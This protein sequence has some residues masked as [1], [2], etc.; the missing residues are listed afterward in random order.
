M[1]LY[2]ASMNNKNVLKCVNYYYKTSVIVIN[3][4]GSRISV[5]GVHMYKDVV[6]RFA[7]FISFLSHIP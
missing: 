2:L 6:V 1:L 7:D 5:K 4:G 3:R